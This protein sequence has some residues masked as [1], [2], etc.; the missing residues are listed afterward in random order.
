VRLA[1]AR[2]QNFR[3]LHDVTVELEEL[4][5]LVGANGSGKSSLLR[6]LDWFFNGGDLD[7][8]DVW[9][10]ED[11]TVTVAATF[12][13]LTTADREALGSYATGETLTLWR[14]WS[15]AEGVKLTGRGLAYPPFEE[16][17]KQPNATD[18]RR[19]YKELR[20]ARPELE[21]PPDRSQAQV[22]EAMDAWE[23]ENPDALEPAEY[24]ATHLFG[25]VGQPK[26]NGRFDYVFV[27]AVTDVQH[28]VTGGRGTLLARLLERSPADQAEIAEKLEEIIGQAREGVEE[29]IRDRHGDALQLLGNRVTAALQQFVRDAEVSLD[30]HP[31]RVGVS[32]PTFALRVADDGIETTVA[33]QGHGL[34]RALLVATLHELARSEDV[35]DVPAVMLAIEEPELYHHPLQARHFADV[36]A[37]LPRAGEGAF[38]VAYATHSSFFVDPHRFERLRRFSRRRADG[39]RQVTLASVA[40]VA[41]R[42][43]GIVPTEEVAQRIGFTLERTLAEAVFADAALI[44]EGRTDAALVSGLAH[45]DAG[46]ASLGI[47][48]VVAEGKPKMALA[49]AVLR[50]LGVPVFVMFDGDRLIEERMRVRGELDEDKIAR[51]VDNIRQQNRHLTR[52]LT[53]A[54]EDWPSTS[55][56]ADYA[57]FDNT[58]E[59]T[60][61][62]AMERAREL[63]EAAGDWRAKSDDCYREAARDPA[64]APPDE[65]RAVLAAVAAK[66]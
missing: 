9:R 5:V 28:E 62:A 15:A 12:A 4:T 57:I 7:V 32:P 63:A 10:H 2:I 60:W 52:L 24:S 48:L 53:G 65:L 17:R 8:D 6:A 51:E 36:L 31:P 1:S 61:P 19:V 30:V 40:N 21:L 59:D 45:R 13:D 44:V 3:C 42:L 37:S 11:V 64:V 66:R 54:E 35:G 47:G 26:L 38:Q 41:E 33:Q 23:T 39:E 46:F 55:V 50:E 22:R 58:I 18:L 34:Q 16:V 14:T 49:W 25:V 43:Q 20:D 56:T 27:P 29:V